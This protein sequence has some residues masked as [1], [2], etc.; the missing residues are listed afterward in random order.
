MGPQAIQHPLSRADGS[1]VFSDDLYTVIVGVN[2]P[3][4]VQRRD[5]LPEEAAIEVNVRPTSGVGGPRE[6]W[7]ETVIHSTLRSILL[8]HMHPRTLIQVTLQVTKEPAS[9]FLQTTADV[10]SLPT[11]LNAAFL[12]LVDGGLSLATTI[13]AVLAVVSADGQIITGPGESAIKKAQSIHAMAFNKA[14][15]QL[16]N[17]S[18]GQF[19][20]STWEKVADTA[21]QVSVAAIA[22]QDEDAA[23]TNGDA[24]A[25][26]WLGETI[27]DQAVAASSWRHQT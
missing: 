13:S 27:R 9:T 14:G 7:L 10:S 16:L 4:D 23:M 19:D 15:E 17:Q 11:M 2:G 21:Q 6:R 5:E 20:Y 26:S 24:Q 22:P 18:A 12:A 25:E 1:T 3:V 8:V